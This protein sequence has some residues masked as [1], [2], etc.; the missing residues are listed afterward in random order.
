MTGMN[1][2]SAHF[3][4]GQALQLL[5]STYCQ[6]DLPLLIGMYFPWFEYRKRVLNRYCRNPSYSECFAGKT[7]DF[8]S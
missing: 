5:L 2:V 7:F 3:D 8:Y 6:M 1:P 4:S